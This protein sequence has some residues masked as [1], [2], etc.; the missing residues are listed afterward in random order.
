MSFIPLGG[1]YS[2]IYVK[3]LQNGDESYAIAYRDEKSKSVRKTIQFL[4]VMRFTEI[5]YTENTN[6]LHYSHFQMTLQTIS[7]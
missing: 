4:L 5:L 6:I 3:T 2:G 7:L 1:K